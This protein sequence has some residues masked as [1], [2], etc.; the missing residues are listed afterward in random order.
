MVSLETMDKHTSRALRPSLDLGTSS[1]SAAAEALTQGEVV[2]HAGTGSPQR[3][4]RAVWAN[5]I[6]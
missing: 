1:T 4:A 2:L 3:S 6:R 5:A